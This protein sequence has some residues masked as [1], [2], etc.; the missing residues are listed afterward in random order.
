MSEPRPTP[1]LRPFLP[2]DAAALA[3]IFRESVLDLTGDDYSP[4]QQ[5]EWAA[6][7]EDEEAFGRRLASGLTLVATLA[8]A[9]V[10]FVS[11]K[12]ADTVDLLY[13]HPRASRRGVATLL[14]DAL[15]KLAAARGA[16]RLT[17][18]ASDT[19]RDFFGK[20]GFNPQRR[21][22]VP[23]GAEWLGSTTMEKPLGTAPERQGP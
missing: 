6:S 14:M 1:G 16:K 20:R 22:S 7:A 21:N 12:G 10:G 13:V 8:G 18:D 4:A 23:R 19:A 2:A 9:P 15:E 5:A 17:V 3:E 11:L